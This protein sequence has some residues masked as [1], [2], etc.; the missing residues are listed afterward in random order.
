MHR[1]QLCTAARRALVACGDLLGLAVKWAGGELHIVSRSPRSRTPTSGDHDP[2]DNLYR[3]PTTGDSFPLT[4]REDRTGEIGRGTHQLVCASSFKFVSGT[5]T[6][7]HAK[8]AHS[9]RMGA[10]NIIM[11]A[12]IQYL[13]RPK[14][15]T[16]QKRAPWAAPL[17]P[18]VSG[19]PRSM[20]MGNIASP[21]RY[22]ESAHCALRSSSLRYPAIALRVG[23]LPLSVVRFCHDPLVAQCP[24]P[25][26]VGRRNAQAVSWL[27]LCR[28]G[29]LTVGLERRQDAPGPEPAQECRTSQAQRRSSG[30]MGDDRERPLRICFSFRRGDAHDV[31]IVDY[32]RG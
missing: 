5:T 9:G 11:T 25:Q 14:R 7:K 27:G 13:Q 28:G 21:R 17:C 15:T 8:T 6:P 20:K 31:E 1:T 16:A 29:G 32:H 18:G 30:A 26:G 10:G 12:A 24:Q 2:T 23:A 19:V 4:F 22:D 3:N